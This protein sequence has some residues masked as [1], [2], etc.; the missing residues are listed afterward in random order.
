M[1][2]RS[3]QSSGGNRR[4][5]SQFSL[6]RNAGYEEAVL[7]AIVET[8][9]R[10]SGFWL[11]MK[12]CN[13]SASLR[14]VSVGGDQGQEKKNECSRP[15]GLHSKTKYC[16]FEALREDQHGWMMEWKRNLERSATREIGAK[17]AHCLP[18]GNLYFFIFIT[19]RGH[20]SL[21]LGAT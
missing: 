13:L 2:S 10:L 18:L 21:T 6:Q 1:S 12:R 5:P 7:K 16:V 11:E 8:E 4:A 14:P 20:W 3:S 17:K 19:L 9:P 15:S